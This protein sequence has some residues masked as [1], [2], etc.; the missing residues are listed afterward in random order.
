[1]QKHFENKSFIADSILIM[2]RNLDKT[3]L[4]D[5]KETSLF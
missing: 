1:M 5:I 3:G 2:D 4:E